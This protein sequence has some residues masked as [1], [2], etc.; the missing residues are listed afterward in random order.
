[1]ENYEPIYEYEALL[2][3]RNYHAICHD[4]AN[5][6]LHDLLLRGKIKLSDI[7]FPLRA[8]VSVYAGAVR[9]SQHFGQFV[10]DAETIMKDVLEIAAQK[11]GYLYQEKL[12]SILDTLDMY[13]RVY[14]F[15]GERSAKE[16]EETTYKPF[17][18]RLREILPGL[19][20]EN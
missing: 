4:Q 5:D 11:N 6:L 7:E 18:R 13:L 12:H 17:V 19:P 3:N 10:K 15:G 20:D 1:M 14:N 9:V 16:F 8:D 2:R